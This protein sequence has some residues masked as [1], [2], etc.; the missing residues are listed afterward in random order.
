M[1]SINIYSE[2]LEKLGKKLNEEQ[3]QQFKTAYEN[4]ESCIKFTKLDIM[5]IPNLED[6]VFPVTIEGFKGVLDNLRNYAVQAKNKKIVEKI[7]YLVK[8]LPQDVATAKVST[9]YYNPLQENYDSIPFHENNENKVR[10]H[11]DAEPNMTNLKKIV[12]DY[13]LLNGLDKTIGIEIDSTI[14]YFASKISDN[15]QGSAILFDRKYSYLDSCEKLAAYLNLNSGCKVEIEQPEIRVKGNLALVE[16]SLYNAFLVA[17]IKITNYWKNKI[18]TYYNAVDGDNLPTDTKK[19]I[20]KIVDSPVQYD[21]VYKA[22]NIVVC[23]IIKSRLSN[24]VNSMKEYQ[25]KTKNIPSV[26]LTEPETLALEEL[27]VTKLGSRAPR[28][29]LKQWV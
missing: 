3:M 28:Q 6:F 23:E 11:N 22:I 27:F 7:D 20:D 16:I 26:Q 12:S 2:V 17:I 13:V 1:S 25:D 4:L 14:K 19:R 8:L 29:Y 10:M 21:S 24:F 18:F 9:D 15:E 5:S